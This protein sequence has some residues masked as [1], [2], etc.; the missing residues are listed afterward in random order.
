MIDP[1]IFSFKLFNFDVVLRWYGVL[2]M[3]GAVAGAW[4]AERE[5]RRRGENGEVIW[6]AM[7]WVLPIGILGA[8][9]WYVANSIFS[10]VTF[11]RE[12]PV[13]ILYIWEG[14][15]HFFGGLLFGGIALYFFLKKNGMDVWLFLDALAPATLLGQAIARPANFINQELYGQ[16]TQLPWGIPIEANHRLAQYSDLVQF[17]VATTRFHPT[18]AYEMILNFLIVLFLW[19]LSRRYEDEL[20]PGALFSAWL[21]LAGLSRTFIEFFRPDQA[22]IGDTFISYTMVVSFGMAIVGA[23][24]LLVR[25]GKLQL[26]MAEDWEDEYQVKKVE[27]KPKLRSRVKVSNEDVSDMDEPGEIVAPAKR[28]TAASAAKATTAKK[29]SSAKTS[30]KTKKTSAA[31][32]PAPKRKSNSE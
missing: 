16:P 17:P 25:F 12:N 11:Y 18:F 7:V 5:I 20:K 21:L 4:W 31:K 9:L 24:M 6:D 15:L 23:I 22:R 14:G 1:I 10:G 29:K 19:W 32:K 30:E 27:D 3:L 13:H 2:V 8:R 26:A 28:K